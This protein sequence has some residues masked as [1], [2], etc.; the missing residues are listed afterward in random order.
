MPVTVTGFGDA[1][2]RDLAVDADRVAVEGDPLGGEAQLGVPLS[3]EEV[4]RLQVRCEVLVLDVDA[5]DLGVPDR[6]APSSAISSV[7][8]T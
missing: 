5:R 7:D 2:Q 6:L 1:L 3:V 4:G 8:W